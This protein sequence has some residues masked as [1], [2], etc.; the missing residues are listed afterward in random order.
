MRVFELAK[1]LGLTSKDLISDLKGIGVT[2]ANHRAALEDDAVAKILA[3][4]AGKAK[5]PAAA[6]LVKLPKTVKAAKPAKPAKPLEEKTDKPAKADKERGHT[7]AMK[8]K[9]TP[10]PVA[11]APKAEKKMILVKRRPSETTVAGDVV[12]FKPVEEP[13]AISAV[14][15]DL[16]KV[17]VPPPPGPVH[18]EPSS[19]PARPVGVEPAVAGPT[20][21]PA[22][23]T[24][25]VTLPP[26]PPL[27]AAE[28]DR[29]QTGKKGVPPEA[30][31]ADL[32]GLKDKTKKLRRIVRG[33]EDEP[34]PTRDDAARWRDLRAMPMHRREERTRHAPSGPPA[35][36]TKPR[37]K[38]VKLSEGL[39]VKD[40][41]EALGQKPAE[42][43]RKLIDM[44]TMLTLNQSIPPDAATLVAESFGVKVEMMAE[45][46]AEALLEEPMEPEGGLAPR[47]PVVTI[48]GH[49]DHG[50]TSLLDAIR[51]TRVTE[52]EA[53]GITQHI[54]A[55]VVRVHGKSI[56]FLDTPG[57]EAFTAMRARG[58]KVTDLV[59][60]VVA[61]DDGVM[62]QTIEAIDH[63]RAAG[64]PLIVALNKMDKPDANPD[65]VKNS[66]AERGLVPEA[67]GGDTIYVEVS[68]KKKTG[69]DTLLEMI[70]LQAEV[71]ELRANPARLAKG[72]VIEAKLDRGRGPVATVLVQTGTLRVGDPFVVGTFS[73]RVRA[74]FNDA[75]QLI[76]E[77]W[78][79]IPA[80]VVGL[81]GVP[82]AGDEFVV[83]KDERISRE[84][85][86]SRLEKQRAVAAPVRKV[87]LDDLFAQVAEGMVK[88]L[89]IIIR[90]DVQG[91]A[92]A[93]ADAVERLGTEAVKPHVL[94]KGVGGVTE[95]DVQ[96]A[97]ASNAIIIGFNVRPE[98]KAAALAERE[99]VDIRTYSII[100]EVLNDIRAA[101]EG[102]LEPTLKERVLGR[103]EVRQVFM[104]PKVGAVAGCYVTDGTIV[105]AGSSVRVVRDGVVVYEGR[106]AS[107]RRF[108][109]DVKEVQAGYECGISVE[110]FN[111]I[112]AGDRFEVF[113]V[114]KVATKL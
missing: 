93:I 77:A 36:V 64:V 43:I 56:T 28:V 94:L 85:A 89:G 57:H 14:P 95:N 62:P 70:L 22:S 51:Q 44:G 9:K 100:Y 50:K 11:E 75:G 78:P 31:Q 37:L 23:L 13:A 113:T 59:V 45:R 71:L 7:D 17:A 55:Y 29:H 86:E 109:D 2:V 69:L 66:L 25:P 19:R 111:D 98:A 34:V 114:D 104:I 10:P 80:E 92:E 26:Q 12:P 47:P 35:E 74:L 3:K 96:L 110:N 101:M 81:L 52:G 112:K 73:G 8:A 65:R 90:A 108:K 99:G 30:P 76:K 1:Q 49:V 106:L 79:S 91:S 21:S 46:P 84:I 102:L 88:D 33:R 42:V 53:G 97:A 39:T 41:A 61:A 6:S 4:A 82:M 107:L 72:T 58:A 60:L 27:S 63:A 105:R 20:G 67:W 15:A 24:P 103:A 40:F 68:A 54:G 5:K 83:T 18:A 87:T 38:A 48:M 32:L 16:F